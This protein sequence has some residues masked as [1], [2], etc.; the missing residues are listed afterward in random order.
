[1][2]SRNSQK[3]QNEKQKTRQSMRPNQIKKSGILAYDAINTAPLTNHADDKVRGLGSFVLKQDIATEKSYTDIK[4]DVSGHVP[5]GLSGNRL[6]NQLFD[7]AQSS[8]TMRAILEQKAWLTVG[9]GFFAVPKRGV[10]KQ[11]AGE[12]TE[13]QIEQLEVFL[14]VIN[15]EGQSINEVFFAVIQDFFTFGNAF[16]EVIKSG[17]KL[18]QRHIPFKRVNLAKMQ[19]GQPMPT[20][21][22]VSNE[23]YDNTDGRNDYPPDLLVYSLFPNFAPVTDR[24]GS[25]V[26]MPGTNSE[27]C[28]LHLK[29]AAVGLDYY[30]LPDW[31]AGAIWAEMEYRAAKYNQSKLE[32]GF[33]PSGMLHIFGAASDDEAKAVLKAAKTA[34]TG[35]GRNSKLFINVTRDEGAG[36]KFEAMGQEN[37]GEF[38]QLT[39]TAKEMIVTANRWTMSLAGMSVGGKLG[40]NQEVRTELE[41]IQNG[42]IAPFQTYLLSS[43]INRVIAVAAEMGLA[44]RGVEL[45]IKNSTPISFLG[46]LRPSEILTIDEQREAL[47]YAPSEQPAPENTIQDGIN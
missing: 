30:G 21:A 17:G 33:M 25:A 40:S 16:V 12:V 11:P 1:L 46:D 41:I 29:Q 44:P 28:L 5:F 47:G 7:I 18:Y 10:I 37:D 15:P 24:L 36:A 13:A 34:L 31:V 14:E 38:M 32:N 26:Q 23:W 39:Q 42:V 20:A 27:R 4:N 43:W 35:T 8:P 9:D 19:P 45:A 6:Y 22:G 2:Q 3:L